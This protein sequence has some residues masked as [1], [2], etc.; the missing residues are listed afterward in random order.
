MCISAGRTADIW[1]VITHLLTKSLIEIADICGVPVWDLYPIA[2]T[3]VLNDLL[4]LSHERLGF[5]ADR[6]VDQKNE[7]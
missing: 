7:I 1:I 6:R 3:L 4:T 2:D 5:D